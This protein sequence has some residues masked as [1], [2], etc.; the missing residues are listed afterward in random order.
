MVSVLDLTSLGGVIGINVAIT[1]LLI[2][3][4]FVVKWLVSRFQR[5]RHEQVPSSPPLSMESARSERYCS[6]VNVVHQVQESYSELSQ[7]ELGLGVVN[8]P[9]R[10]F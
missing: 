8:E 3:G 1:L 4:A 7:S 6:A 9:K 10:M 5:Q 2:L